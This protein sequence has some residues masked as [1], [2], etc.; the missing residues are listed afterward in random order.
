MCSEKNQRTAERSGG[1]SKLKSEEAFVKKKK[2]R[3]SAQ[4]NQLNNRINE[5]ERSWKIFAKQF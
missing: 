5:L 2:K 4:L 3:F 1:N